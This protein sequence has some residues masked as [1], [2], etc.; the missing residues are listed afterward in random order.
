MHGWYGLDLLL[1]IL[2]FCAIIFVLFVGSAVLGW[3][4]TKFVAWV[5]GIKASENELPNFI[6]W[7]VGS[8]SLIMSFFCV[9][10]WIN[11]A[12]HG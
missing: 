3:Y 5:L 8:V 12:P 6:G 2:F 4:T 7:M 11:R 1:V 9:C 10:V